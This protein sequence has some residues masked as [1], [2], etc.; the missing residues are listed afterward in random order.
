MARTGDDTWDISESVGVTAL[1]AAEWRAHEAESE[2]PLFTDPYA[3]VFLDVAAARGMSYSQ[4]T[5]DMR[6][7][8]HDIDPSIHQRVSA[9]WAYI[10][11]RTRWFDDFFADAGAA[12]VRQAVILAAGLDARAWRLPWAKDSVVFEIDQPKMLEFKSETLGSRGAEPAC[13]YVAVGIDLR[14][15]WPKALCDAGFDAGQ[16]TAWSAEGLLA[17]L[18]ADGQD[19]LFDRIHELSAAGSRIAADVLTAAFFDPENLARLGAW[20]GR[21]RDAVLQ[22]GGQLPDTP[23][24][25]FD[26]ERT[27]VADWLREHGWDVDAVGIRAL[28]ARYHRD[29]PEDD[30]A[31]IPHCD[32]VSGRL[33]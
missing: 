9:Q 27:D 15:D 22:A 19:K 29:V 17:Y 8:L 6:A 4:Y 7:R 5:D 12:D 26:E 16:P 20:F 3:Q 13:R 28:M 1:G 10:A 23:S 33:G 30:A 2:D 18:P 14:Q 31:G 25:W 24:M 11:S 21:L 32:L